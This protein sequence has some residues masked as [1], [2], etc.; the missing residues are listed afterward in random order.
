MKKASFNGEYIIEEVKVVRPTVTVNRT[1]G[2]A[3]RE[4]D[5]IICGVC[6]AVMSC[7]ASFC[8]GCGAKFVKIKNPMQYER[9]KLKE[10]ETLDG[11]L[12]IDDIIGDKT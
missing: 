1:G 12:F 6:G 9:Y 4:K 2:F 3:T 8:M 7:K 10:K 5:L 11:Q